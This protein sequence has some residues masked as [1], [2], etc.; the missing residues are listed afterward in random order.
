MRDD[1]FIRMPVGLPPNLVVQSG[2]LTLEE[3]N[4]AAG[5]IGHRPAELY[6]ARSATIGSTDDALRAGRQA[7]TAA[8]N[9]SRAAIVA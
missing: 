1:E 7:A 9:A 3:P 4:H 8:V 6:S 5:G 2:L